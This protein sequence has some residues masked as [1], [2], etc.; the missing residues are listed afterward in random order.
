MR[1]SNGFS[2]I[3][4]LVSIFLLAIGLLGA[5]GLQIQ[6]LHNSQSAYLR[7]QATI[8]AY[9]IADRIRANPTGT[10]H[11][12]TA[13]ETADCLKTP[14]CSPD[15]MA[16]HDL[17]EWNRLTATLPNGAATVCID[18]TPNTPE[19]DGN[20][21]QHVITINWQADRSE[22]PQTFTTTFSF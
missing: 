3:E 1:Q 14:G 19:C 2:L 13:S 8:A 11:N 16:A 17:F 20:T 10:Y 4:V 21:S 15:Q 5:A 6:A 22:N 12:Q 9:D 18:S 7:T